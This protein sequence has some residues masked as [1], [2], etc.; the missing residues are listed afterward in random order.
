MPVESDLPGS[1]PGIESLPDLDKPPL[2]DPIGIRCLDYGV[3]RAETRSVSDLRSFQRE[4]RPAFSAVRWLNV[5]GFEAD[6]E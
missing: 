2:D 3:E 4:G 6:L 1:S 5:G